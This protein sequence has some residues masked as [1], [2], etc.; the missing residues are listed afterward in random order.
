MSD[1]GRLPPDGLD[2]STM[3]E[4]HS[5]G[6]RNS[7]SNLFSITAIWS[8]SGWGKCAQCRGVHAS[9]PAALFSG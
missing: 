3:S 4:H 6:Q 2:F 1:N 5:G 8:M 9:P 7:C